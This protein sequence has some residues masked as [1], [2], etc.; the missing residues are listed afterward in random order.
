VDIKN[1]TWL[2][3]DPWGALRRTLAVKIFLW[4]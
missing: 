4:D 3:M 2:R 1:N